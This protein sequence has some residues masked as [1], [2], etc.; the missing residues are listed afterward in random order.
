[1]NTAHDPTSR[2]E[3]PRARAALGVGQPLPLFVEA[4]AGRGYRLIAYTGN[5]FL[6]N[7]IGHERELPTL[8]AVEAWEEH[9]ARLG[10]DDRFWLYK[11]NIGLEN[12][13]FDFRNPRLTARALGLPVIRALRT[14]L[15]RSRAR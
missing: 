11:M 6:R 4:A 5:A 12:P 10:E 8:D 2:L 14:S 3:I 15:F 9:V 7:D 13:Y 1:M